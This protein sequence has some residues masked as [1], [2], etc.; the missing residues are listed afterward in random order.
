MNV[1]RSC[2]S[3]GS[4]RSNREAK[5]LG[6]TIPL[7]AAVA[8]DLPSPT[9]LNADVHRLSAG[10]RAIDPHI[11]GKTSSESLRIVNTKVTGSTTSSRSGRHRPFHGRW[12][13]WCS[14]SSPPPAL[15]VPLSIGP[16]D[17]QAEICK[18]WPFR[19]RG[20]E[21]AENGSLTDEPDQ[22]LRVGGDRSDLESLLNRQ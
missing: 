19:R 12:R 22:L 3:V 5:R 8:I 6:G 16:P 7:L 17:P 11:L 18:R 4:F 20:T 13:H 15:F 2:P 14:S 21:S 9:T 1:V 10:G